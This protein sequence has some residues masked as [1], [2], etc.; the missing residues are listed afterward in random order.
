MFY[1]PLLQ[2]LSG[3]SL[4]RELHCEGKLYRITLQDLTNIIATR[5]NTL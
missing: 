3:A 4:K 1:V 2:V 5:K